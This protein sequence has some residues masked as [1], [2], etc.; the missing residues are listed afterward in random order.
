[1]KLL[2]NILLNSMLMFL[3][4]MYLLTLFDLQSADAQGS[5]TTA[6]DADQKFSFVGSK[7]CK[8]CHSS[9]QH[10]AWSATHMAKALETLKPGVKKEAKQKHGLDPDK[11]YTQDKAC[12]ACH[13]TGLGQ[14]GYF[15][16]DPADKKSVRKAAKFEGVGCESCHG[17]GSEYNKV[18]KDI[19]HSKRKYKVEELYA[20]GLKK[21]TLE[22][23][24][25][26]HND[27][28][29][30]INPSEPFDYEKMKDKDVHEHFELKQ[31]EG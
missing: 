13:T 14:G 5:A 2:K 9:T 3:S 24:T 27:K 25:A 23:C 10:K 17:P 11:D 30:T 18:F 15:I 22:T 19:L 26:C 20:V 12:L 1:M 21:I 4:A 6:K 8:K 16:P 29:P 28:S 7:S 31:R